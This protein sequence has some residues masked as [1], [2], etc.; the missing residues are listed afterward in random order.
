M[1]PPVTQPHTQSETR[2]AALTVPPLSRDRR[3]RLEIVRAAR[4]DMSTI[5]GF[6]RS[7]ADWYREFL[8]PED[9]A[10]H[11]VDEAWEER[12][13]HRREFYLGR[14]D[15]EDVGTISIQDFGEDLY[16]GYIYL[17]V[18]QVGKGY[19]RQL[20]S[21]AAREGRRRGKSG[22]VLIAHPEARWAV[23]AYLKAGF[24]C[25]ATEKRDVLAWNRGALRGYYEEGFHLFRK[26]L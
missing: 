13:F 19:G 6:I 8:S 2:R 10:E 11:D 14:A 18:S 3:S 1:A 5:A 16:L 15:D 20:T 25:I 23:K 26:R 12:N 24:E 21:F 7:S 9:M 22:L 4:S 17:D